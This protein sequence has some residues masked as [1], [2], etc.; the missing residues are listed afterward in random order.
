MCVCV[1]SCV[2]VYRQPP[3][4][5]LFPTSQGFVAVSEAVVAGVSCSCLLVA[6]QAAQAASALFRYTS[7][8]TYCRCIKPWPYAQGH[9]CTLVLRNPNFILGAT[10]LLLYLMWYLCS[11]FLSCRRS[12]RDEF[13]NMYKQ[14]SV[15]NTVS[16]TSI[17]EWI[18]MYSTPF[19]NLWGQYIL[20]T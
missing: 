5:C 3:S 14:H 16:H 20:Y 17:N 15:S 9:Q 19:D 2:R 7:K 11:M 12:F 13:A 4:L 6:T 1:H 18:H 10:G 8:H